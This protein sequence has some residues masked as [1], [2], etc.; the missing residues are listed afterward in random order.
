[1]EL[2]SPDRDATQQLTELSEQRLRVLS[3][4][5][6]A[7][8]YQWVFEICTIEPT[9][10]Q[11]MSVGALLEAFIPFM[12]LGDVQKTPA[13]TLRAVDQA[14]ARTILI[15][16]LSHDLA[17]GSATEFP[18]PQVVAVV[19]HLFQIFSAHPRYFTNGNF[20]LHP[21]RLRSWDPLTIH[22]FDTGLLLFDDQHIGML[23]ATEED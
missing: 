1:M 10:R 20:L 15:A 5:E 12:K 14:E 17:Y 18:M 9:A 22:T 11:T 4:Q 13:P 2:F 21:F 16:L 19:E 3:Y 6:D 7:E 23:W 8:Y